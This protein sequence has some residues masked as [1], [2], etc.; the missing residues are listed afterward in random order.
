[1]RFFPHPGSVCEQELDGAA[2]EAAGPR[3]TTPT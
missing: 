2:A 3:E 1:M